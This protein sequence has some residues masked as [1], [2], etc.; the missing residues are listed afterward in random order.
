MANIQLEQSLLDAKATGNGTWIVG[1][2][3]ASMDQLWR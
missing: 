2:E 1:G 3:L